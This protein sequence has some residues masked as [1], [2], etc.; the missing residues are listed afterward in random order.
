MTRWYYGWNVLAVA[1]L[2]QAISFGIG[3]YSFTF[4]VAP[5]MQEFDAGRADVMTVF[6]ILQ[7]A[8]GLWSPVAGRFLDARSIRH[9][10]V[11]G[12]VCL[13]VGLVAIGRA[14]SLWQI[15][16]IYAT[17][18]VVGMLL[19][20]PLPAQT[21]A[22]RW[23]DRR[24]GLAIG[25]V[26]VGTSVG[27]FTLPLVVTVLHEWYGWRA[28]NDLLAVAVIVVI[29]PLVWRVIRNSPAERGIPGEGARDLSEPIPIDR[30][31]S[32]PEILRT[33]IF[34]CIVFAFTPMA[35]AFGGAQQNLAPFA[36]D[37]GF[38]A[39]ATSYLVSLMALVMIGSKVMFGALA[40]RVAPRYLFGV[41]L[42]VLLFVLIGLLTD[43]LTY[44][45]LMVFCAMLGFS[46][47]A[48]LPLLGAIVTQSFGVASFARVVGLVGPFTTLAA[49]GP[50]LAG[51]IRDTH[52]SYDAA[53]Q[54][55][56]AL[57]V[58]AAVALI[59]LRP[60]RA[61]AAAS[62]PNAGA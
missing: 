16:A 49:L 24:R 56:I 46:A 42:A 28:A 52:G 27:G 11:L 12:A 62:Q 8:M 5:W 13:S 43:E 48:F 2:F 36:S 21:L 31:W 6:I 58:P 54:L 29:V 33:R 32:I 10:I 55:F 15:Q 20:G 50:W 3:I 41:A 53:W 34:W 26:T 45:H 30:A 40:D 17:L 22:A 47:G 18:I 14:A 61:A 59:F 38:D 51:G 60:E 57:L 23:F 19:C 4:W 25:I 39:R 37:V 35:L 1:M 44:M 9:L 7:V